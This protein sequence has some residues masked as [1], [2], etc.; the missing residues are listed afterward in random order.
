[1]IDILRIGIWVMH[2]LICLKNFK[3]TPYRKNKNGA[4][5]PYTHLAHAK[6]Q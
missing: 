1:M 5:I 6:M 4:H 3:N 2:S